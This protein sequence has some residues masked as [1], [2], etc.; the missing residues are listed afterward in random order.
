MVFDTIRRALDLRLR[1]LLVLLTATFVLVGCE[2]KPPEAIWKE[3]WGDDAA[4]EGPRVVERRRG[5]PAFAEL[6]GLYLGQSPDEAKA[7]LREYCGGDVVRRESGRDDDE[8]YFLGCELES[9]GPFRFLR[10]GFWPKLEGRV[11]VIE[12]KRPST[13]PP[14]MQRQ[15]TDFVES[16]TIEREAIRSHLVAYDTSQYRLYADW[17]EGFDSPAHLVIGFVPEI[18]D[19]PEAN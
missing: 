14:A 18:D 10:I 6:E 15:F 3:K 13:T 19:V 2:S 8:A 12:V 17:D 5:R 7:R 9:D 11:A 1:S 4:D 16:S